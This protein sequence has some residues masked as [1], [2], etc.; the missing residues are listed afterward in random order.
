MA[1]WDHGF[2]SWFEQVHIRCPAP[3]AEGT[4]TGG[5]SSGPWLGRA[6]A[7]NY[8]SVMV[9]TIYTQSTKRE[10]VRRVS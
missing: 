1:V 3:L 4:C 6:G 5:T 2:H 8:G 7:S 10:V 9:T